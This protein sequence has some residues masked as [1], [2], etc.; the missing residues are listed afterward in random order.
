MFDQQ[1]VDRFWARVQ[2]SDGY[3]IW[4]GKRYQSGYGGLIVSKK[5][6]YAH[7]FSWMVTNGEI[8]KLLV[9]HKCDNPQC[10]RPDHLFLGT[11]K[12]NAVDRMAKGRPQ[13]RQLHPEN[14]PRGENV[15]NSKLTW[16]QVREIRA[17][18]KHGNTSQR[19]LAKQYGVSK[20][21]I[22]RIVRN[23]QW[24]EINYE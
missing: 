12:D 18:Y 19:R 7:R 8:G 23:Q 3:L 4:T 13:G 15:P 1:I 5:Q 2:K 10:V 14:Y 16:D 20:P 6:I 9:L 22:Q 24:K 17:A 21:T 11:D